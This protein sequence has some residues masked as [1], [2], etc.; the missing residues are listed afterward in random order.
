MH[1]AEIEFGQRRL[2]AAGKLSF[3][4][5]RAAA[6]G[7]VVMEALE[8]VVHL[9]PPEPVDGRLRGRGSASECASRSKSARPR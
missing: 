7:V 8:D 1:I 5:S 3:I 4:A 6:P 2:L 9:S